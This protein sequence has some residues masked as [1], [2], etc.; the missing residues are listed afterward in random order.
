MSVF[1]KTIIPAILEIS[2]KNA[3]IILFHFLLPV[4]AF[5]PFRFV[6]IQFDWMKF[7][8]AVELGF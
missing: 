5:F 4:R 1:Y 2:G 7:Q 3:G 6:S 8:I